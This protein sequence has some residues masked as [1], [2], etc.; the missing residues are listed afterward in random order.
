[1]RTPAKE[2]NVDIAAL[3]EIWLLSDEQLLQR[4]KLDLAADAFSQLLK[5]NKA[6]VAIALLLDR[7]RWAFSAK[8]I[9]ANQETAPATVLEYLKDA[10]R[11][12]RDRIC[13]FYCENKKKFLKFFKKLKKGTR[14]DDKDWGKLLEFAKEIYDPLVVICGFKFPLSLLIYLLKKVLDKLC[15]C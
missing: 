13:E 10:R 7:K 15:G 6:E 14:T 2:S 8:F 11:N 12:L 3:W 4:V 9:L 5:A 1:M